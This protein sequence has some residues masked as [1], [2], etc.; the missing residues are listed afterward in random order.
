MYSMSS[1]RELLKVGALAAVRLPVSAAWMSSG[2]IPGPPVEEA[3]VAPEP[4]P[5]APPN[6]PFKLFARGILHQD[7]ANIKKQAYSP[8]TS[9]VFGPRGVSKFC[10]AMTVK[11]LL[12][13][14]L[15]RVCRDA[16]VKLV[17]K[18]TLAGLIAPG[19]L[20]ISFKAAIQMLL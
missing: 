17:F 12:V 3:W 7:Q 13:A 16:P 4:E 15:W 11:A 5:F 2:E 19:H 8:W 10:N 20:R 9:I 1:P 14:G 18:L 6:R